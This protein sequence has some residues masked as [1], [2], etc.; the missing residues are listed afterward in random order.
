M[1][2]ELKGVTHEPV[3]TQGAA[4]RGLL[5]VDSDYRSEAIGTVSPVRVAH[6]T[7]TFRP[8]GGV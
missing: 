1:L 4:S 8:R 2:R 7:E 3:R 6:G 5:E